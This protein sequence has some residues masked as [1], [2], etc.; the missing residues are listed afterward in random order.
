VVVQEDGE[1][2]RCGKRGCLETI[3]SVR[4]VLTNLKMNSLDKVQAAFDTGDQKTHQAV[5]HAAHYLGIS[6]ANL[7][8]TLNIQKI[9][10]TGDMTCFGITWLEA[11]NTSM[12]NAAMERLSEDTKL[13]LGT[14]DYRACILGASAFLML[15]DYSLL[16]RQEK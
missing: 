12:R 15:D 3:S 6:L 5:Q 9:I 2:C 13:E 8:G 4:A 16:F 11:V 14:L 1:L 10:L 7:I